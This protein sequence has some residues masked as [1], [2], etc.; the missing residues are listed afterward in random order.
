MIGQKKRALNQEKRG[1]VSM[2]DRIFQGEDN[3]WYYRV[4]GNHEM[5]PFENRRVAEEALAKQMRS[6]AGRAGPS[7]TWS[8]TLH[9]ARIFRRS[10]PRQS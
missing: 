9:P 4:R 6:W 8:R 10:A 2:H 3:A 7:A 5:G 1:P